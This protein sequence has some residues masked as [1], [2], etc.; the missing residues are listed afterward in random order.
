MLNGLGHASAGRGLN[1]K[2]S[3][4]NMELNSYA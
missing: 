3:Q 1:M 2:P 4:P